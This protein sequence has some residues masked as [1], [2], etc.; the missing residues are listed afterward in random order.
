MNEVFEGYTNHITNA[1]ENELNRIVHF[2]FPLDGS[3]RKMA[4]AD[5]L[6]HVVTHSFYHRG[7]IVTSLK[8]KIEPLPLTTYI[9]FASE[10]DS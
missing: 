7:Q 9:A 4:V 2:T 5:A 1:D 10:M 6:T 8:G 3:K